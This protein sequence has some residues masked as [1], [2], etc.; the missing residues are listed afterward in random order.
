MKILIL[1]TFF[2][3]SFSVMADENLKG[4][5]F[6]FHEEISI[7]KIK[8]PIKVFNSMS[9]TSTSYIKQLH[10]GDA[11]RLRTGPSEL[12]KNYIKLPEYGFNNSGGELSFS[13]M[14]GGYHTY[15]SYPVET[16]INNSE[17]KCRK[18]MTY[19]YDE[20]SVHSAYLNFKDFG[21]FED[22]IIIF[23]DWVRIKPEDTN[24][25]HPITTIKLIKDNGKY[26]LAH[27]ENSWQWDDGNYEP[28]DPFDLH[29]TH[30]NMEVEHGRVEIHLNKHYKIDFVIDRSGYSSL[31][32]NDVQ[33]SSAYYQTKS[34]TEKHVYMWGAYWNYTSI[35]AE[36]TKFSMYGFGY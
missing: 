27:Y 35:N 24:G 34:P 5:S 14:I 17:S 26:Y 33:V 31:T 3:V 22:W 25:N 4:D 11:E 28:D 19:F 12:E 7:T 21:G 20:Y 8:K 13:E 2:V 36:P 29:H 32:V 6:D 18:A 15:T 30:K 1:L 16:C 10:F 23:Q 9:Q